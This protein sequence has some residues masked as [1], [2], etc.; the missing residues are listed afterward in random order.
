[1][2]YLTRDDIPFHY[3][4]AD[5]FTVCERVPLLADRRHRPEPLHMWTGYT[6]N[7]AA[8]GG[9]SW[10]TPRPAT[11][12]APTPS[13]WRQAGVSW[14][15]Y[16][17]VGDGLDAAHSWGWI[18]DAYRGNYGDNSLLYFHQYQAASPRRPGS[19]RP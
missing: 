6:G 2:A 16:Q 12:G 8:G 19:T 14:K 9:R 17:D 3:A 18:E 1:M 5:A 11:G 7:D 4:L 10:T 15:I 13:A